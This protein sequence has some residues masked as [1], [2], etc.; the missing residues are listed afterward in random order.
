MFVWWGSNQIWSYHSSSTNNHLHYLLVY[1]GNVNN[2]TVFSVCHSRQVNVVTW[3]LALPV[4]IEKHI[5]F[6][7]GDIYE[8]MSSSW[9][10]VLVIS[11]AGCISKF[12]SWAIIEELS[13]RRR[14]RTFLINWG[15]KT[16]VKHCYVELSSWYEFWFAITCIDMNAILD[17][18]TA[19]QQFYKW[20]RL[21]VNGST[22]ENIFYWNA[23]T[24]NNS[25]TDV[26]LL[27]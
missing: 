17:L 22:E 20:F 24:G 3:F 11:P 27:R 18:S 9:Y 4:H 23:T 15:R 26:F 7:E 5:D 13:V 1:N 25:N 19:I 8:Y 12:T 10:H 6:R 14:L 21:P 2:V 16:C